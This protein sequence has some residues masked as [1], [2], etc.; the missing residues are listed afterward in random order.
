MRCVIV[1]HFFATG[2]QIKGSFLSK[3]DQNLPVL[4]PVNKF[5]DDGG[6]SSA[7]YDFMQLLMHIFLF[8]S[9]SGIGRE[10]T[11]ENLSISRVPF[12]ILG[13]PASLRSPRMVRVLES[14]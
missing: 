7:H 3:L 9:L 13:V 8:Y 11:R 10:A 2:T 1:K 14:E 12:R 6:K 4:S 5:Q